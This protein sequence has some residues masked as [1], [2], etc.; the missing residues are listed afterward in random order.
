MSLAE[1]AYRSI[2]E[3]IVHRR[4]GPGTMISENQLCDELKMGRTPIREALQR[5]RHIGFVEV[6]ARRG[7]LVS[8]VD[9]V[10]QLEL[11]EVRRPLEALMA[12][13]AAARAT[14]AE[15]TDLA[16]LGDEI[17]EAAGAEDAV[18]YFRTNKQIHELSARAA[19]NEVLA[20]TLAT[21]HAQSRRF[22]YTYVRELNSFEEGARLHS[23]TIRAVVAGDHE[24]AAAASHALMDFLEKLTRTAIERRIV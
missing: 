17:V 8:T 5:L 23:A 13:S 12:R 24:G 9:V 14:P 20:A 21:L 18:R 7:V 10:R 1:A 22:W 15:R 6:H 16:R 2:E 4:L 11:I 3:M 19:H